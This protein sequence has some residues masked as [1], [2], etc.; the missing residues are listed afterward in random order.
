ML[1]LGARDESGT[2]IGHERATRVVTFDDRIVGGGHDTAQITQIELLEIA[3][4][5]LGTVEPVGYTQ[6]GQKVLRHLQHT[7]LGHRGLALGGQS[8]VRGLQLLTHGLHALERQLGDRTLVLRNGGQHFLAMRAACLQTLGAR[9]LREFG[10]RFE[11]R[12]T[13]AIGT[14]VATFTISGTIGTIAVAARTALAGVTFAARATITAIVTSIRATVAGPI[15]GAAIT[16]VALGQLLGDRLEV[17]VVGDESE[18]FDL[19]GLGAVLNHRENFDAVEVELGVDLHDV[20]GLG[21]RGKDRSVENTLGFART[22]RSPCP[23]AVG[24]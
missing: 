22:G 14:T 20:A 6:L 24:S 13:R 2:K 9:T 18:R 4:G 5:G 15:P 17:A 11:T 16:L 21:A 23:G 10:R 3:L 12:T 19:G 7:L 8:F 1:A